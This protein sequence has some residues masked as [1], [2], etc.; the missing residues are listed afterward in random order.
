MARGVERALAAEH[1]LFCEAGTGTGKT[2]AYLV[3]A[4]LSGKKIIISTATRALQEQLLNQDIP[5]V[6]R[7]LG[8][9]VSAVGLKGLGNYLCKRRFHEWKHSREGSEPRWATRLDV[10]QRWQEDSDGGDIAELMGLSEHD[11]VF[12]RVTSSSDTRLGSRC[13]FHEQCF[14]TRAKRNAEAA[15]IVVVNHHLF[16]ADLALR[17]PHPG[18][19]LPDY[20]AV[21]FDE[22]H[23]LEDTATLFFGVRVSRRRISNLVAEAERCFLGIPGLA[24]SAQPSLRAVGAAEQR[25]FAELTALAQDEPRARL[26]SDSWVGAR[27]ARYLD[28]DN[29]LLGLESSA[30]VARG[31]PQEG[32]A[33]ASIEALDNIAR[34]ARALRDGLA[35]IIECVAGQVTWLEADKSAMT[36]SSSPVNLASTLRQ[37]V[38][39]RIPSVVLTSATL[40]TQSSEPFRFIRKRLGADSCEAEVRELV[41]DSPFDFRAAARLYLTR[42]LPEPASPEFLAQATAEMVRLIEASD[43]GAFVLTTSLRSMRELHAE[44]K[45]RLPGRAVLLQGSAPKRALLDSFQRSGSAVLVATMSFWEGVDVPGRALRLVILE[46]IPFAVPTDPLTQARAQM[47]EE[48]G[49]NPFQELFLPSAQMLLKQGFG[50]L[51]R[52]RRDRGVVALLDSRVLQRG[53]GQA[54]LAQLP[55]AK[56]IV[57]LE[58]ACRFL[59]EAR[60]E[61]NAPA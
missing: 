26:S 44:L 43:G 49:G 35:T 59:E 4:I 61:E 32:I 8:Q 2:F 30:D 38:F 5:A 46:K 48:E 24:L 10:L 29:A 15:R 1:V 16:F 53:Y 51:I 52:T 11:E 18:R 34:R 12:G 39:D 23:Q 9:S 45:P 25:F 41:V 13:A 6:E 20:E 17:G 50:R 60:K 22:A 58:E 33:Q 55:P 57:D 28:L 36:L 14:V 31:A 40:A 47:I 19:V 56:R 21:I 42:R 3:P 54:L 37:R 7:A 27:R